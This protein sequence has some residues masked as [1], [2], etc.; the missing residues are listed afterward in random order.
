MLATALWSALML[1]ACSPDAGPPA[2]SFTA[3]GVFHGT[4]YDGA[5]VS[6]T[7]EAVPGHDMTAMRM[8]LRLGDGAEVDDIAPGSKVLLTLTDVDGSVEVLGLAT[9]P[10]TTRL[11]LPA[12]GA[13]HGTAH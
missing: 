9:L 10:D 7:H 5:A 12:P 2:G 8:D 11:D 13:P 4:R 1:T 6:V 3:R